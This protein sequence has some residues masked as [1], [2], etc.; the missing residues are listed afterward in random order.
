MF[1]TGCAGAR[2]PADP[3]EPLNRSIYKFNDSVD[4]AVIKPVAQGYKKVM[5][6]T[7]RLMVSNFFSN[8]NDVIV[9]AND[10][11]QFKFAQGFS[12]GMR[13]VVNST[14][15]VVGLIDVASTS[16]LKKH[17]EDFGQTLGKWG[18]GS[19]PY[20]VLP[21]LGPS[22]VRDGLGFYVDLYFDPM[23]EINDMSTR[24]Q[25]YITR[26]ISRRTDLLDQEKV[27]V[28]AMIDPYNFYR[29]TYLLHRKSLVFD[30]NLPRARYD[31][32]E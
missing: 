23:Y 2:N 16:G 22:S 11:L 1:I 6:E 18:I 10:F 20:L 4:R 30:G 17:D 24:N 25:T 26:N 21:I 13:V 8:L 27:L 14:I 19:G 32:D 7:G 9:T 5:P 3:L 15:G 12:D 31:F 29:D 28:E